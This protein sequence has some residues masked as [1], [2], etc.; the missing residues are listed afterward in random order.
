MNKAELRGSMQEVLRRL[1]PEELAERSLRVADRLC[2]MPAWREA[3]WLFSFLSMP[4]EIRTDA[5]IRDAHEAGKRVAV[6]RIESGEIRFLQMPAGAPTPPRD[7]WGIPVPDPGW[8]PVDPI[9]AGA[10]LVS[11]PGLAFDRAGNRLGRGKGYYDRFLG[12]ARAGGARL[13]VIGICFS[14]QLVEEVPHTG[15][16]Q[17]VDGVVTDGAIVPVA[18]SDP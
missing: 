3:D 14:E 8:R 9:T 5:I 4:E 1:R 2:R 7:R 17:R 15:S 11:A 16:D 12:R 18:R 13:V 10:I 6:P